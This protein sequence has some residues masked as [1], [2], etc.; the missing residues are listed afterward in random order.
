[1]SPDVTAD[2]V[3]C[4][5]YED[6]QDRTDRSKP[7]SSRTRLRSACNARTLRPAT[8]D[9]P[10][11]RRQPRPFA[12][13]PTAWWNWAADR[14]S[15]AGF[16]RDRSRISLSVEAIHS[17]NSL[18]ATHNP[19]NAT[20]GVR[21]KICLSTEGRFFPKYVSKRAQFFPNSYFAADQHCARPS[22]AGRAGTGG[23]REIGLGSLACRDFWPH[24]RFKT[25][26][27]TVWDRVDDFGA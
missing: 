15:S 13:L 7:A 9:R 8:A 6:P 23:L 10:A 24:L 11:Q 27:P 17:S 16:R 4:A 22:T 5:S 21:L 2:I 25:W 18:N 20:Y 26:S 12:G 1:M 14:R 3:E 19:V